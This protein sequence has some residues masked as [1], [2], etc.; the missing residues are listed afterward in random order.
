MPDVVAAVAED[1][2]LVTDATSTPEVA[3]APATSPDVEATYK[4]RIQGYT[5]AINEAKKEAEAARK[6]AA[7]L[8]R[9]KAEREQ[10]EMSELDKALARVNALEAEAN[11]AKAEANAARLAA[12]YPRAA[13]LLGDDLAKFD[14]TR[15][16]EIDGRLAKEAAEASDEPEPRIDAN[17]PRRTPP[18]APKGTLSDA[19]QALVSAGNPFFTDEWR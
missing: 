19:K 18:A 9:W 15:V 11:A 10:A 14:A 5:Q 13:E 2:S 7:D 3:E 4:K 17:S 1:G 6:E 16:A 8:A 12:K